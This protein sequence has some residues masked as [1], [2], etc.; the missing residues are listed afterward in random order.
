M[1]IYWLLIKY[2][3]TQISLPN[4]TS[5]TSLISMIFGALYYNITTI[6]VSLILYSP[7]VYGIKKIKLWK[8]V[9][10][11]FTGFLLTLTTPIFYLYLKD[12]KHNDYYEFRPEYIAW[13][14]CFIL[15]IGFYYLVNKR[16]DKNKV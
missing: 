6:V 1:I 12:W 11:I 16:T 9:E 10:L 14:L 5:E 7:I 2:V 8:G 15:S 3:F 13:I 4:I